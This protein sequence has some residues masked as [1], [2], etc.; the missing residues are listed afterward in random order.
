MIY[1]SL[2]KIISVK[3]NI[4]YSKHITYN[5]YSKHILLSIQLFER[6]DFVLT[7]KRLIIIDEKKLTRFSLQKYKIFISFNSILLKENETIKKRNSNNN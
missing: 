4:S 6:L 2:I 3:K 7:F 5:S 1:K